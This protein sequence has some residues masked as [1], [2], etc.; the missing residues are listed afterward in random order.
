[1]NERTITITLPVGLE[2]SNLTDHLELSDLEAEVL[3]PL[4][5]CIVRAREHAEW[6]KQY[7]GKQ[8]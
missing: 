8:S 3:L 6:W 2:C 1:M 4:I 5:R 7:G